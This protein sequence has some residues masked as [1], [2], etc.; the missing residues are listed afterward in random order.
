MKSILILTILLA[1]AN[2]SFAYFTL[3]ESAEIP[4]NGQGQI[5]FLPQFFTNN[6]QGVEAGVFFGSKLMEDTSYRISA[7]FGQ[8]DFFTQG[9]V[10]YV[11]FA[12]H[13]N[14]PAV[15]IRGAVIYGK[16]A[17][18]STTAIQLT[19]MASK[20]FDT[21]IG[22]LTPYLGYSVDFV[23]GTGATTSTTASQ[24]HAG[25]EWVW[26]AHPDFLWSAE[27]GFNLKD[28]PS[29]VSFSFAL[30]LDLAKSSRKSIH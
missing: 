17:G 30:P 10:K 24:L 26:E 4:A 11:P 19:P 21:E 14:T 16:K 5:G 28:A 25:T 22:P 27:L 23:T 12:D 13:D 15:G 6:G 3:N 18:D 8:V 1:F 7:G 20:K 29:Y 2:Q 9:S